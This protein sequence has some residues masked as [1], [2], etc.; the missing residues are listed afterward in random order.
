MATDQRGLWAISAVGEMGTDAA[1]SGWPGTAKKASMAL[2]EICI[3]AMKQNRRDA[4]RIA[5]DSLEQVGIAS[6]TYHLQGAT[7]EA[8]IALDEVGVAAIQMQE[9]TQEATGAADEVGVAAIHGD[10]SELTNQAIMGLVRMVD[11]AIPQ[12]PSQ[13]VEHTP[14]GRSVARAFM[15]VSPASII[16]VGC[17]ISDPRCG[18][19]FYY[20]DDGGGTNSFKEVPG[21]RQDPY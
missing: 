2:R 10:F 1:S 20:L 16:Q 15:K 18:P 8:A 12:V 9:A 4:C 19:G 7:Q 21:V 13:R 14:Y 17:S 5:I 6:A 11:V 3:N